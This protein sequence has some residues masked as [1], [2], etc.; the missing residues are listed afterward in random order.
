MIE[1][2]CV[3]DFQ[4]AN[5]TVCELRVLDDNENIKIYDAMF[6][7]ACRGVGVCLFGDFFSHDDNIVTYKLLHEKV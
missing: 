4:I 7:V 5:E 2:I 1:Q 3:D 6:K